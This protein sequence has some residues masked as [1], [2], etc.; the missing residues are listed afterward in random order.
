M[1][2]GQGRTRANGGNWGIRGVGGSIRV[3]RFVTIVSPLLSNSA[4]LMIAS[5]MF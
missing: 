5:D 2:A 1:S 4:T 3:L